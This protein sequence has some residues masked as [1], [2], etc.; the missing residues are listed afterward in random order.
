MDK[1]LQETLRNEFLAKARATGEL[2]ED[3]KVQYWHFHR[4][5]HGGPFLVI[6]KPGR[7]VIHLKGV[8]PNHPLWTLIEAE[9]PKHVGRAWEIRLTEDA[10]N[11]RAA[12]DDGLATLLGVS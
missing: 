2:V 6:S 5:G 12:F 11:V 3:E 7:R 9:D 10:A 8:T 1:A 4:H